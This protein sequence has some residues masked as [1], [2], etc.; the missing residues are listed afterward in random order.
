MNARI[1]RNFSLRHGQ[2]RQISPRARACRWNSSMA[3]AFAFLAIVLSGAGQSAGARKFFLFAGTSTNGGT[4]KGIYVYR[5]DS[6]TG[7]IEPLGLAAESR[8]PT[9]LAVHPNHRFLYA[10]NEISNFAGGDG[11]SV[12]AFSIDAATGRLSGSFIHPASGRRIAFGGVLFQK[13][14]RAGGFFVD[15]VVTGSGLSGNVS[16]GAK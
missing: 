11:G 16:L 15:P 6:A 7:T 9:F 3:S 1:M 13:G 10:V 12:T 2:D 14:P 8:S 5:Y 4:S